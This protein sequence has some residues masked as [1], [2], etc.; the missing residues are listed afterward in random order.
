MRSQCLFCGADSIFHTTR[1]LE[2]GDDSY[3]TRYCK[4]MYPS[5]IAREIYRWAPSL[6][7]K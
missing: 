2:V 6:V 7:G 3:Q 1:F 5:I 4:K